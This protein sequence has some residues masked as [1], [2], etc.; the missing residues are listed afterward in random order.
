VAEPADEAPTQPGQPPKPVYISQRLAAYFRTYETFPSLP[1]WVWYGAK[2]QFA[3]LLEV[4]VSTEGAVTEVKIKEAAGPEVDD[5]LKSAVRNWRYRPR[6][7]AGSPRPFCH[8]IR[9]VYSR[10]LRPFE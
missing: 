10:A 5:V 1:A 8:P 9:V 7:V 4:C 3:P 6:V 2:T